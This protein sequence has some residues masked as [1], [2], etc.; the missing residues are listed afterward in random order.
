M[1]IPTPKPTEDRKEFIAR[2]MADPVMV[3]EYPNQQQRL[4]ICAVQY[5]KK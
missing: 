4:A 1:P 3:K 2:C 5:R